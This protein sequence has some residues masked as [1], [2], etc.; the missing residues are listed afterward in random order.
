MRS[1]CAEGNKELGN[2]GKVREGW[3]R[4]DRDA[5]EPGEGELYVLCSEIDPQRQ[6][7]ASGLSYCRQ[8]VV[9]GRMAVAA[10][11]RSQQEWPL[12]RP[13]STVHGPS[14]CLSL[15]ATVFTRHET[16]NARRGSRPH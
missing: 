16:V 1:N 5:G 7:A 8:S 4:E 10:T 12:P 13:R 15:L 3:K 11:G 6:E 14:V 2:L 9:L